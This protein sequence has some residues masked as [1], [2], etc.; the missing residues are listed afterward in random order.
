MRICVWLGS[1]ENLD[2]ILNGKI[3]V[4]WDL[5]ISSWVKRYPVTDTDRVHSMYDIRKTH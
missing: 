1:N 4:W 3:S 2:F 5:T